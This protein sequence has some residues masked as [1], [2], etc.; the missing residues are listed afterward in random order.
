MDWVELGELSVDCIVGIRE[1]EQRMLQP[2]VIDVRMRVPTLSVAARTAALGESV[3]YAAISKQIAFV[4]QHGQWGLIESLAFALCR[5]VLLP[6]ATAEN[7]APITA[8]EVRVRKPKALKGLAV[9]AVRVSRE[10]ADADANASADA[11]VV[12]PGV[13][14]DVLAETAMGASYRVRLDGGASW[15]LPDVLAAHVLAGSAKVG[16]EPREPSSRLLR[17]G[18]VLPRGGDDRWLRAEPH[19][20][21]LLLVGP[22]RVESTAAAVGVGRDAASVHM[23]VGRSRL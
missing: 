20:A 13:S 16:S 12:S 2:L 14:L 5:L 23:Q 18:D 21:A 17:E 6:P 9:P 1:R 3:N 15:R 4:A 19:G 8:A 11:R 10:L 22:I 7:R